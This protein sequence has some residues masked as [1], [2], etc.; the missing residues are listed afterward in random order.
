MGGMGYSDAIVEPLEKLIRHRHPIAD[1][2]LS[3]D[4]DDMAELA[5]ERSMRA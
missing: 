5:A 4:L 3:N 2:R 1:E